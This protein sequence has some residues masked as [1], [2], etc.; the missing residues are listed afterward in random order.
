MWSMWDNLWSQCF[1][2]TFGHSISDNNNS[3][4]GSSKFSILPRQPPKIPIDSK[5]VKIKALLKMDFSKLFIFTS[6]GNVWFSKF[7]NF[8]EKLIIFKVAK[9]LQKKFKSKPPVFEAKAGVY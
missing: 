9:I 2:C 4:L 5:V 1:G 8:L 3:I 7:G 6:F